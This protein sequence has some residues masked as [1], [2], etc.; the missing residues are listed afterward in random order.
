MTSHGK[1]IGS[2]ILLTLFASVFVMAQE[3]RT[4]LEGETS[5]Q[6]P[7]LHRFHEIIFPMWHKAWPE[8]NTAMLIE[9]LPDIKNYRDSIS[10]VR[11]PGIL[12]DKQDAWKKGVE[13]LRTIVV[14]YEHAS[15]TGDTAALLDA[16]EQ[17]HAQYEVL[18]RITRPVL[19]ELD[20]FHQ[21]LYMLYHHHMPDWN[22][23]EIATT[24]IALKERM[25]ALSNA[26][27]PERLKRKEQE[28]IDARTRLAA[29]VA[30]LDGSLAARDREA[31]TSQVESM[32]SD[33]QALEAIF[34]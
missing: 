13:K 33:Y 8:K 14:G 3:N 23:E 11:L 31:F 26:V 19:K 18:V 24:T 4:V 21:A 12:R 15:S 6:I 5:A 20:A 34:D 9:L 10:E 30:S 17:L 7:V 32:H 1:L 28:F 25:V 22:L 29:S 27:L 16:A 2:T